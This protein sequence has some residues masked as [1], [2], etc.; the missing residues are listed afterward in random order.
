MPAT[1]LI[2]K[3]SQVILMLAYNFKHVCFKGN[4]LSLISK[5]TYWSFSWHRHLR[6]Y[7]TEV[8]CNLCSLLDINCGKRCGE[9]GK[10][11]LPH[12]YTIYPRNR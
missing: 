6:Q 11:V 10:S 3:T 9:D 12:T 5:G 8:I 1:P 4:T 7:I 2:R